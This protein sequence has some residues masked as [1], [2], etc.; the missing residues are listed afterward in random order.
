V[1]KTELVT[2]TSKTWGLV[3]KE[4]HVFFKGWGTKTSFFLVQVEKS[5]RWGGVGGGATY[6]EA[7]YL[8]YIVTCPN[9]L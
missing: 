6:K 4:V 2:K 5:S 3:E 1:V 9:Q 7:V 8:N